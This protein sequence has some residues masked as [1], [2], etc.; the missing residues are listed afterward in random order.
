MN[1]ESVGYILAGVVGI[2][3]GLM[4]SGGSIL[5]VPI[6]V[7]IMGLSPLTA[8]AYSLFIVGISALTGTVRN[9]KGGMIAYREVLVFGLPSI[10]SVFLTRLL[11]LPAIPDR[12]HLGAMALD[13]ELLVMLLFAAVM[14]AAAY[15]M[16]TL[17]SDKESQPKI[18]TAYPYL[19]ISLW[20][21]GIGVIA[22]LVGAG[23]GFL[24]VPS[25]M[26]LT[27]LPVKKAI[28]SSLMIV[29]I[30]S[31]LGFMGDLMISGPVDWMLL[32]AFSCCSVLGIFIGL[33]MA[34]KIKSHS[35]KKMF[36]FSVLA[37]GL[38]I[39]IRELFL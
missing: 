31:L 9:I 21:L 29:A 10:T 39:V 27:G 37:M 7:Y 24:I 22:G 25:L 19:R 23:G 14:M 15:S 20:A 13:K 11:L 2:S 18:R 35:L 38:Y 8:T 33:A 4:G 6:L 30:Q 32:L 16:F 3:L 28:A 36:A 12:I 26:I 17:D 34:K 5:T 1:I